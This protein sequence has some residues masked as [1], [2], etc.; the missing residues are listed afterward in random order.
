MKSNNKILS[1]IIIV[2]VIFSLIYYLFNRRNVSLKS[3][4]DNV[5]ICTAKTSDNYDIVYTTIFEDKK[6]SKIF[7]RYIIYNKDNEGYSSTSNQIDYYTSLKGSTY[8][9]IN[10]EL[11]ITL[12]KN[13]Y[14]KNKDDTTIRNMFQKHEDLKLYYTK[15]GYT[16]NTIS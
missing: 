5:L 13:T 10:D 7:I 9:Y 4:E 8:E 2:L 14:K 6:V 11:T 16:C 12:D 3:K 1:L 15:L